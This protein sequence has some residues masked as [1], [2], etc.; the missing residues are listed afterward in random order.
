MSAAHENGVRV[1]DPKKSFDPYLEAARRDPQF[2]DA[3]ERMLALALDFALGGQ[4]PVEA[5]REGCEKLLAIDPSAFKAHL[6]LAEID[7][8]QGDPEAAEVALAR[9]LSL[10]APF[11][12]A[13]ERMGTALVRQGPSPQPLPRFQQPP[14]Q[15]P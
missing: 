14:S 7:L 1:P 2:H 4:G 5:A 15:P 10:R 12:P 9:A 11:A 8:A 6:A 3:Q 13:F